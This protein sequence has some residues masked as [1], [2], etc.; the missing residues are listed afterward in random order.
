MTDWLRRLDRA[1]LPPAGR[2]LARLARGARRL[3]LLTLLGMTSALVILLVAVWTADQAPLADP[4]RG[5]VVRVGVAA[6]ES[7]PDY[8]GQSRRRVADLLSEAPAGTGG[9]EMYALVSLR[10]YLAPDRLTAVFGGVAVSRVY[11]RVP[12]PHIQTE[13]VPIEAYRLPD[14]V[15]AGM[16]TV[17]DRKDAQAEEYRRR[18]ARLG[19]ATTQDARERRIFTSVA[20]VAADEATAYR[21]PCSCVYAAVIRATPAALG[22]IAR[23]A[24]VRAVDPAPAVLRLDRAVFLPPLPEQVDWVVPPDDSALAPPS[25]GGASGRRGTG[26]GNATQPSQDTG[27]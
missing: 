25:S 22:V 2:T 8:V 6:G 1:L 4:S 26:P 19:A 16:R 18:A 12:L 15:V 11:A 24:E 23:R 7:V 21:R 17:A 13:I 20:A 3:R 9:T 5:E 14:D 10:T 27:R